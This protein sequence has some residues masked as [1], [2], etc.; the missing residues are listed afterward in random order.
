[1]LYFTFIM[2]VPSSCLF[3]FKCIKHEETAFIYNAHCT[4]RHIRH[5]TDIQISSFEN[6]A[7]KMLDNIACLLSAKLRSD[8][9]RSYL[10]S[11]DK[12]CSN[13]KYS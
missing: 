10:S 13:S 6:I 2:P 1:M 11:K 8:P 12:K 5:Q 9:Q 7:D 4:V 3:S